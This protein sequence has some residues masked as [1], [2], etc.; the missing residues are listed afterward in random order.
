MKIQRGM[1]VG[2]LGHMSTFRMVWDDQ[3]GNR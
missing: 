3:D 2:L 1:G